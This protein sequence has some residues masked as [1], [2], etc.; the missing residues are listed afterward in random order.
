MKRCVELAPEQR[1]TFR[2]LS[3][4]LVPMGES[5]DASALNEQHLNLPPHHRA[6]WRPPADAAEPASLSVSGLGRVGP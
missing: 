1:P 4:V 3:T 6:S 2:E 5:A